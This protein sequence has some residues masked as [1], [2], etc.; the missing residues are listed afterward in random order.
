MRRTLS[1]AAMA[2]AVWVLVMLAMPFVG[3]TGRQVA[4][5]GDYRSA[6]R[7]ISLSGGRIVEVRNHAVLA[8]SPDPGFVRQLYANG[9]R[10]VIEGRIA[11]GCF[12]PVSP[13]SR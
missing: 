3:P 8:K 4:V 6:V 10:L 7:A 5:V 12:A 9:A 1:G 11:A 2:L 13:V